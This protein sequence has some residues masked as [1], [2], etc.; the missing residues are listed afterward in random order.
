MTADQAPLHLLECWLLDLQADRAEGT[1]KRYRGATQRFLSWY[2]QQEQQALAL[3][4][5]T[6]ITLVSYRTDLQ[7]THAP[8]TVNTHVS[9]LR[10]WCAWLTEH[11]YL[12]ENPARRFK[13]VGRTGPSA[14]HSLSSKQVHALLRQAAKTR[15]PLRDLALVQLLL[16]TGMRIGECAALT[17]G[18]IR[19]GEKQG[20][21]LI[22]RGKGNKA[23]TV[24]LNTSAR[25][26]LAGY[27]APLLQVEP[28]LK[29][30]AR[31]W[32]S[33]PNG[34]LWISQKGGRLSVSAMGRVIDELVR[35]C[36]G[37]PAEVSAHWLRHTFAT[38]YLAAH[39]GDLV[40]LARLLGHAS[41]DT[42]GIYVQPTEEQLAQAVEELD[43]NAYV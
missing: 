42:T 36:R 33:H 43:V 38:R 18:D 27:V 12:S 11:G 35:T 13:L 23:R 24:P 4:D 8:S 26:A 6:P 20:Q 2:Q 34:P 7:R 9:A 41:L 30:V 40:G 17:W 19:F 37:L 29:A 16:Q 1:I 5:L 3:A 22:R 39:P 21:A 25:T 31:V 32:P 15:H 10:A 14:P 28:T